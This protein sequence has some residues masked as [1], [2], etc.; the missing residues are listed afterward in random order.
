[1]AQGSEVRVQGSGR[2]FCMN[3]QYL[4][5][6]FMILSKNHV[7]FRKVYKCIQVGIR[8][9]MFIEKILE[10]GYRFRF[11]FRFGY[12]F[13]FWVDSRIQGIEFRVGGQYALPSH[14]HIHHQLHFRPL[15]HLPQIKLGLQK[16]S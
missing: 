1:M 14:D 16:T 7:F 12:W 15:T 3:A 10:P 8:D 9:E 6:F 11:R 5:H 13:N 2:E 4:V